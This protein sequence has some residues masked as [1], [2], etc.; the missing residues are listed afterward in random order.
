MSGRPPGRDA[1]DHAVVPGVGGVGGVSASEGHPTHE[2]LVA[3]VAALLAVAR[4]GTGLHRLPR[5]AASGPGDAWRATR[6]A[7]LGL[8]PRRP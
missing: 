1:G 3:A 5:R 7:A 6:L 4:R 2:E 8:T